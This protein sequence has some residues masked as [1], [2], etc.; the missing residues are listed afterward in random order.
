MGVS[1]VRFKV[2][3]VGFIRFKVSDG[4]LLRRV[5]EVEYVQIELIAS[6]FNMDRDIEQ[7]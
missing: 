3:E 4:G 6:F 7:M 5:P 1:L 2:S